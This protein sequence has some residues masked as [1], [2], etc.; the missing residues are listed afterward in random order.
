MYYNNAAAVDAAL[1]RSPALRS[2]T[3][4]VLELVIPVVAK[5]M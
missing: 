3:H 5:C 1:D 4:R 2:F